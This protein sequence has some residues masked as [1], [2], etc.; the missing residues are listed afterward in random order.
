M[1]GG[2]YGDTGVGL[3]ERRDSFIISLQHLKL[4]GR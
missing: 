2:A 1:V 3:G 4:L